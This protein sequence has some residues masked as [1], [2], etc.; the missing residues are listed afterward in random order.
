MQRKHSIGNIKKVGNNRKKRPP[1]LFF[2]E[3]GTRN[4]LFCFVFFGLALHVLGQLQI[5]QTNPFEALFM[6]RDICWYYK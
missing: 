4:I 1:A 6:H 3:I 5:N 2:I